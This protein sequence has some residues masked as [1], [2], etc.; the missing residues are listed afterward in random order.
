VE[1][2]EGKGTRPTEPVFEIRATLK[3]EEGV[4][5]LHGQLAVARMSLPAEPL[6]SQWTR[7]LRQLFQKGYKL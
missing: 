6:L 3:P 1:S 2:Q 5:L 4:R 7:Q